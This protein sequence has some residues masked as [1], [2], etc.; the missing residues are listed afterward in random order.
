MRHHAGG[1]KEMGITK[2]NQCLPGL[3]AS[4]ASFLVVFLLMLPTAAV[5]SGNTTHFL[6]PKTLIEIEIENKDKIQKE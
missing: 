4:V 6:I 2:Y 3:I 1:G 5:V